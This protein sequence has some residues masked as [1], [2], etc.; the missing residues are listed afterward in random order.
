MKK[1]F[2]SAS[3]LLA[4]A[5]LFIFS[6]ATTKP[7]V[8][9]HKPVAIFWPG[10]KV[11]NN[12]DWVML[13]TTKYAGLNQ[14]KIASVAP[15]ANHTF[16]GSTN[17]IQAVWAELDE[18]ADIYVNNRNI[19]KNPFAV[20]QR[21]IDREYIFKLT[22]LGCGQNCNFTITQQ[23]DNRM[24]RPYPYTGTTATD[25]VYIPTVTKD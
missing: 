12:T 5:L 6:S 1:I 11:R 22:G 20:G 14:P 21:I 9:S 15:Y 23:F 19:A 24:A 18:K 25:S 2:L 17:L 4:V 10:A 13:V 16:E 8:D 7:T 3:L